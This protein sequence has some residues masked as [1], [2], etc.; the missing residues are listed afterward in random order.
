M[1]GCG[2]KSATEPA[3]APVSVEQKSTAPPAPTGPIV[4]DEAFQKKLHSA[5]RWAKPLDEVEALIISKEAADVEDPGNGNRP[6]HIAAQNGHREYVQLLVRKECDVNAQNKGG[7]TALHMSIQYGYWHTAKWMLD[8]GF[9][10]EI[11]NGEGHKAGNGIDGDVSIDD[12]VPALSDSESPE[13]IAE[14]LDMLAV[15][16]EAGV[17]LDRVK[18]AQAGM[19]VKKKFK[20]QWSAEMDAKFKALM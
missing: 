7:Q 14:A 16:K 17:E 11:T 9:D 20:E 3:L 1:G 2:S 13:E 6:I 18:L 19:G 12:H 10:P 4:I 8:N 15:D 5:V